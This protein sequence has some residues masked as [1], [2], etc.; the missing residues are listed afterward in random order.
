MVEKFANFYSRIVESTGE[1]GVD[2]PANEEVVTMPIILGSQGRRE[3]RVSP[4]NA[5]SHP[6]FH[7]AMRTT[8]LHQWANSE[9]VHIERGTAQ[10]GSGNSS[11]TIM[12]NDDN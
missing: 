12:N 11:T 5:S 2:E 6:E 4:K 8:T 1:V 10:S 9:R 7:I 3:E